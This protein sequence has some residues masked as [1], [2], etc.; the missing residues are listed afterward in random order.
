MW[1]GLV[2]RK[3]LG[4][5]SKDTKQKQICH[6]LSVLVNRDEEVPALAIS[7]Q[8]LDAQE[9]ALAERPQQYRAE[10]KNHSNE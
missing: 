6:C 10:K 1:F 7:T 9:T 5:L 4:G 3:E 8:L 2:L